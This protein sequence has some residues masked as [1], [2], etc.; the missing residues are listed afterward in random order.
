MNG[1]GKTGTF[2]A[3]NEGGRV[4]WGRSEGVIS[5]QKKPV[6]VPVSELWRDRKR[7]GSGTR[8]TDAK[9]QVAEKKE[10]GKGPQ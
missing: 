3:A 10:V 4:G 5:Y 8:V 6:G 9:K 2:L 1:K 7:G